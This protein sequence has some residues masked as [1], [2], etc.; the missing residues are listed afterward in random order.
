MPVLQRMRCTLLVVLL[1]GCVHFG[2]TRV[3]RT[4]KT[5]EDMKH[6]LL[7]HI[8]L[9]RSSIAEAHR[10]M[11]NEGFECQRIRKGSFREQSHGPDY[12]VEHK[13]IDFLLCKRAE[14]IKLFLASVWRIALV[15]D[16]E[17]VSD[18]L[19]DSY[20]DGP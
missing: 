1:A 12:G 20:L 16:G 3:T 11:E 15:I 9:Q 8:T 7:E 19:I 6:T 5:P 10:F 4:I 17:T 13:D 2:P 18:V 14:N